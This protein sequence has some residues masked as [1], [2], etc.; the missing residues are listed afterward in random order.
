MINI[1]SGAM[2]TGDL[3]ID[4][5]R[6]MVSWFLNGKEI[7]IQC[8]DLDQA[9]LY[10]KADVVF[11][12]AG[13]SRYPDTLVIFTIDGK[14]KTKVQAPPKYAFSYLTEDLEVVC[15]GRKN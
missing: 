7:S 15:A 13:K 3:T 4:K 10:S 5:R 2:S 1:G 12:L 11:V 8:N 9:Y 6:N 14:E